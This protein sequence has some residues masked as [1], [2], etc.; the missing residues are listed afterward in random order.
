ME[1]PEWLKPALLGALAGGVIVAVG[2]FTWGGWMTESNANQLA[3]GMANERVIAAL[4][5]VCVERAA[6]D[7]E[8]IAKLATIRQATTAI[9]RRDAVLAAGWATIPDDAVNSRSLA[10]ACLAALDLPAV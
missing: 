4:V 6:N 1:S 8:R 9:S 7:P 3:R 5:P 2:G 10:T